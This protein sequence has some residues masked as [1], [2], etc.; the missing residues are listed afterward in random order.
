MTTEDEYRRCAAEAHA[1]AD[2][3]ILPSDKEAWLKIAHSW[4][5]LL[6]GTSTWGDHEQWYDDIP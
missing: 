5:K 6:E 1:L 4:M 3:A 2:K